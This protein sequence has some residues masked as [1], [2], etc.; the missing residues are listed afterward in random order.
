MALSVVAVMVHCHQRGSEVIVGDNSHTYRFEQAGAAQ[1]AGVQQVIVKNNEDGTFSLDELKSRIRVNPDYH[2][3]YT[4]LV[5]VENTHNM[6]GGKV[7][8]SKAVSAETD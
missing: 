1:I 8:S 2:E 6:C 3:P 4:S 7:G 5:I